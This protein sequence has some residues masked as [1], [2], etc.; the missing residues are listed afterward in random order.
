MFYKVKAGKKVRCEV[1]DL[2]KIYRVVE[3][4]MELVKNLKEKDLSDPIIRE[5]YEGIKKNVDIIC[6]ISQM[7]EK[8]IDMSGPKDSEFYVRP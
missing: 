7:I 1:S 8:G 2:I 6:K 4:L 3:S 5:I